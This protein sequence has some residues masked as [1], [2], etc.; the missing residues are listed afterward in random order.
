M[1]TEEAVNAT[2]E[3]DDSAEDVQGGVTAE[4][5]AA[6]QSRQ[7]ARQEARAV[8]KHT[9]R[10]EQQ[11]AFLA[12]AGL[13]ATKAA[14]RY[15]A[16]RSSG[17]DRPTQRRWRRVCDTEMAII[18][19]LFSKTLRGTQAVYLD[20]ID[21]DLMAYLGLPKDK[22]DASPFSEISINHR[23]SRQCC[24]PKRRPK[25]TRPVGTVTAAEALVLKMIRYAIERPVSH[26]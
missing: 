24:R 3:E 19:E 18:S 13:P 10:S 4:Q 26:V 21:R 15:A 23:G 7:L 8:A 20:A 11:Q 1:R 22:L 5:R 9:L 25:A 6:A 16:L 2:A 14:M 17:L 12:V